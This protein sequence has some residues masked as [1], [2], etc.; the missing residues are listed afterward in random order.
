MLLCSERRCV[1]SQ[2]GEVQEDLCLHPPACPVCGNL[3][4]S[5][6]VLWPATRRKTE[7][8]KRDGIISGGG[9]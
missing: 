3:L 2:D 6:L 5:T 1:L 9:L 4:G 7:R 8:G